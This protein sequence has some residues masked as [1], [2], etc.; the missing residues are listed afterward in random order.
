ME[1]E[2]NNESIN[3]AQIY[4]ERTLEDSNEYDFPV[5]KDAD[6]FKSEVDEVNLSQGLMLSDYYNKDN[7]KLSDERITELLIQLDR[8][9][10]L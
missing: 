6:P 7:L 2:I 5:S 8:K 3:S 10:L 1:T 4:I 9:G